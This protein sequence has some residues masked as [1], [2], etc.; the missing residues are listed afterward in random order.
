GRGLDEEAELAIVLDLELADAGFVAE[1]GLQRRH[2]GPGFGRKGAFGIERRVVAAL[3]ETSITGK[4]RRLRIERTG[5]FGGEVQRRGGERFA[6]AHDVCGR[7]G[8]ARKGGGQLACSRNRAG[9]GG[10][11]AR[12]T[13]PEREAGE[14]A[15]EVGGGF[16]GGAE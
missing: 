14:R 12:T 3:H 9:D 13:A 15:G 5:Q 11:V 1:A 4:Q 10:E 8:D 16:E 6:Q 7:T 2:H